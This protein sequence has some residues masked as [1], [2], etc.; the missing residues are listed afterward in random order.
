[1]DITTYIKPE[2]LVLVPVLIVIGAVIK[3]YTQTDNKWIP[4]VLTVI[5]VVLSAVWVLGTMPIV[6]WADVAMAILTS[7]V[8]GVL[9]AGAAVYGNQLYK[10]LGSNSKED[11]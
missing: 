1:M 9:V 8:Q 4:L 7:I 5:G 11:K 3:H 2:L 10:Q 6:A